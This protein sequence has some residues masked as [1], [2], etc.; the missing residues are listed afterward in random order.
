[1]VKTLETTLSL[2]RLLFG[3]SVL[4]SP[5]AYAPGAPNRAPAATTKPGKVSGQNCMSVPFLLSAAGRWLVMV[6]RVAQLPNLC[7]AQQVNRIRDK[8]IGCE[9]VIG[10]DVVLHITDDL[11]VAFAATYLGADPVAVVDGV[12]GTRQVVVVAAPHHVIAVLA[13]GRRGGVRPRCWPQRERAD[14]TGRCCDH[15]SA[16]ARPNLH[17]F[18]A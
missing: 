5:S 11:G 9:L 7:R 6:C 8:V 13:L 10:P 2:S 18:T 16:G 17:R 12:G 3:I 14:D 1:M 4:L 15:H